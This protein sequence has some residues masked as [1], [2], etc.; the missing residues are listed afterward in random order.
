M[1]CCNFSHFFCVNPM[2]FPII[3]ASQTGTAFELA[4]YFA[5]EASKRGLSTAITDPLAYQIVKLPMEPLVFFFISTTG[6]GD[7]P[8]NF[9]ACWLFLR[10]AD[11]PA[12]SL[13]NVK[14]AIFGLGD[15]SYPR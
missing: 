12:D 2:V 11:L 3:C 9:K 10:R 14:F 5:Y 1:A 7:V 6:R 13:K 15:S 4:E 8:A